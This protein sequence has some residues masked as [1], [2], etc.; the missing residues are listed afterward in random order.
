MD[1][2]PRLVLL[3]RLTTQGESLY[4]ALRTVCTTKWVARKSEFKTDPL[5]FPLRIIREFLR[6]LALCRSVPEDRRPTVIV[7]HIG[8]DAI[9]ALAARRATGC[10]VMLYVVGRDVMMSRFLSR[11]WFLRW[12]VRKADV[13]LCGNGRIEKRVRS[14]GGRTTRVLPAPFVPFELGI[15]TEREFDVVTVGGLDDGAKQSL[16]VEAS[17]YLEPSVKIAVI[18]DGPQREY[19]TTLSRRDGRTQVTFMGDLPPDRVHSTLQSSRLYVQCSHGE[20]RASSVLEAVSCGLPI[21]SADGSQDPELTE[22]YGIRAIVPEDSKAVSLATAI[23]G[24]IENYSALLKDVFTN[25]QAL[26]SFSRSWAGMAETAIF[27]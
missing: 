16:L 8:I 1:N 21:I 9:P 26:E 22:F 15:A 20:S 4:R 14:L 23:E 6:L 25:R 13:V 5:L 12:A 3:G 18:G 7:H 19:L 24:A 17:E 11:R 2:P 27:S 10:K